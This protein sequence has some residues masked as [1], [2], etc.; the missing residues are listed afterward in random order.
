MTLISCDCGG[1]AAIRTEYD[2][3]LYRVRAVCEKCGK[4]GR[5]MYDKS[6]PVPGSA[7]LYFAVMSW[8]C[9]LYEEVKP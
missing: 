3:K 1:A 6:E 8:N 5:G 7:S 2:G 4:A 9:K